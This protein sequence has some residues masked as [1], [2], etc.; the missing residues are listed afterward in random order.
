MR[1]K[2]RG[3]ERTL[4]APESAWDQA[5]LN[6]DINLGTDSQTNRSALIKRQAERYIAKTEGMNVCF[7]RSCGSSSSA[8]MK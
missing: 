1:I 3:G 2:L 6:L 4:T 5:T 7:E 8:H